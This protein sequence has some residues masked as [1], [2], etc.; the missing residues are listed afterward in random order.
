[1]V[2]AAPFMA[3][4]RTPAPPSSGGAAQRLLVVDDEETLRMA[5]ARFLASRG[6]RVEAASSGSAALSVL[7]RERFVLML[8]DIRMPGM[9]GLDVLPQ[10]LAG[11]PDMAVVML[12]AVN[13]A[14]TATEA[15]ARGAYD[16]L[17]KPVELPDLAGAV[18]RALHRRTLVLE[19]RRVEHLI[20]E[21]VATR[22]KELERE[23]ESLRALTVGVAEALINAME[24]KDPYMLGHSRRTAELA[25]S[26]ADAMGLDPDVVEA[27]R[28]AGRLHDV[29]KIGIREAVLH[30]PDRLTP[31]EY[32]HVKEHVRIGMEILAP[33]KHLGLVLQFIQDHHEHFD[34]TGYPRGL[35]GDAISIGGRIL[36]A[37]D[38]FDALTS[39]RAYREPLPPRETIEYLAQ[40]D[41]TLLDP[42]VY[43]VLRK[44]V[45]RRRTLVFIDDAHA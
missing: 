38:A 22:T 21:E 34:G 8:C 1:M 25:A 5:L 37:A 35:A 10:A 28:L 26:M 20:R 9:T 6:Y 31:A 45:L 4:A 23:K 43:D 27:V 32:E 24:A 11:D 13:D 17:V 7:E 41:G 14:P 36:A 44:V 33:L 42:A 40:Y 18:E 12:T 19:Q 29:G 39:K 16:Y 2:R 15:L 30:K 3:A